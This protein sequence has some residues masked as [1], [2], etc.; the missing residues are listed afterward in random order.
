MKFSL[1]LVASFFATMTHAN[2]VFDDQDHDLFGPFGGRGGGGGGGGMRGPP[3]GPPPTPD[4]ELDCS[5]GQTV[6]CTPRRPGMAFEEG[7]GV[8]VC[9]QH[10]EDP[11]KTMTMCMEATDDLVMVFSDLDTCGCCGGECPIACDTSTAC[12][13]SGTGRDGEP[14]QGYTMTM[15][16]RGWFGNEATISTCVPADVTIDAK[17]RG[18]ECDKTDCD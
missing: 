9:I 4:V 13:C 10:P 7:S 18:A 12:E 11:D 16:R 3:R 2:Y 8:R 6:A 15:T 5:T 14:F 17:L 1:A